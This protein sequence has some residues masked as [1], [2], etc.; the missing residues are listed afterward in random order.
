[1]M[2]LLNTIYLVASLLESIINIEIIL[3]ELL[4]TTLLYL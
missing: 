3:F 4:K 2:K 1:M